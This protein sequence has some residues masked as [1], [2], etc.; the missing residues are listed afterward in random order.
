MNY[1]NFI[2]NYLLDKY[3]RS[4]NFVQN[5]KFQRK[6]SV[7]INKIFPEYDD[8]AEYELFTQVNTAVQTLE[9]E[10]FITISRKKNGLIDSIV[11]NSDKLEEIYVF[12]SRKP[13]SETNQQLIS[14][15][16]HYIAIS[17]SDSLSERLE[18]KK[19]KTTTLSRTP[20]YDQIGRASCRERV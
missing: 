1:I 10:K 7:K 15:L 20:L 18:H 11:L 5:D 8:E 9:S 12:L 4:K 14:L 19:H 3:E 13:K 16:E 17:G 6:I 2:L